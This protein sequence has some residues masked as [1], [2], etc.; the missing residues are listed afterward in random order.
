MGGGF[1]EFTVNITEPDNYIY[2]TSY[3]IDPSI[4]NSS[5]GEMLAAVDGR[6]RIKTRCRISRHDLYNQIY[7]SFDCRLLSENSWQ[8]PFKSSTIVQVPALDASDIVYVPC[9]ITFDRY[10]R[11]TQY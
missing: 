6:C 5:M 10:L 2:N 4:D 7:G 9:R 11:L 3:Q 1:L 8:A